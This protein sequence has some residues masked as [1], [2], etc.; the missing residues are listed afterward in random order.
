[1]AMR[2]P[3]TYRSDEEAKQAATLLEEGWHPAR[4]TEALEKLTQ[5]KKPM[6]ALSV[7]VSGRLGHTRT[8][9]D[10]IMAN[11]R[12]AAKLRSCCAAVNALD[13]YDAGEISQDLFP[14]HDVEV[15]IIV[16][17]GRKPF[18][19]QNRIEEYRP[20]AASPVVSFRA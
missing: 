20:V 14:G 16:E 6:I 11:D 3:K 10:W 8:L 17:K 1:M 12:G 18:P 15:K 13:A 7:L 5:N 2:L 19:D 9:P 4:I